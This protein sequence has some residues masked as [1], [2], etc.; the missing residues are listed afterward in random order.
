MWVGDTV[1]FYPSTDRL[2]DLGWVTSVTNA[3]SG[4]PLLPGLPFIPALGEERRG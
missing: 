4:V 2:C 3:P 1:H